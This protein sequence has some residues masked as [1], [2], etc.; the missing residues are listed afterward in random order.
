M[1]LEQIRVA[2]ATRLVGWTDAPIAWNGL[3]ASPSVKAAQDASPKQPWI[4]VTILHGDGIPAT[5]D[6]AVFRTGIIAIQVFT[7][8]NVGERPAT[9]LV[10]SLTTLLEHWRSGDLKTRQANPGPVNQADGWQQMNVNFPFV[11]Y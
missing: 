7:A 4:R 10:D 1:T 2:I 5:L 9:A 11:A 3:P 6:D 8:D